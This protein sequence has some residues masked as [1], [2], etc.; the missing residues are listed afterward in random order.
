MSLNKALITTAIVHYGLLIAMLS[1]APNISAAGHSPELPNSLAQWYKPQNKRQVWLHTMFSMRRELQA[2]TEYA[3]KNDAEHAQKWMKRL[4]E[5]HRKMRDMVPEW[6][7]ESDP[8]LVEQ[9]QAAVDAADFTLVQRRAGKLERDCN[10]CHRQFQA[11]TALRYRWPDFAKL[12]IDNG[13]GAQR[14]YDEHMELLSTTLN[15]VRIA[16]NDAQWAS[17]RRSLSALR[18]QLTSLGKGCNTCHADEAPFRRILGNETQETFDQLD[19]ALI[20]QDEKTSARLLGEAAVQTCARCHGV[21]RLP[22]DL[23]HHLFE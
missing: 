7:E 15:R 10:A 2:V 6:R 18:S 3:A 12:Q 4:A 14:S 20:T 1:G 13:Q 11:L 8:T 17:A 22:T 16:S 23:Q 5:H 19:Q 21:H 9:L